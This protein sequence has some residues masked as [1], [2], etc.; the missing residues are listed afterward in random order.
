MNLAK[1]ITEDLVFDKP[2]T[3]TVY[4]KADAPEAK[5]WLG[6]PKNIFLTYAKENP[7][8]ER[9]KKLLAEDRWGT[10]VFYKEDLSLKRWIL[11]KRMFHLYN[12]RFKTYFHTKE[13]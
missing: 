10:T 11:L 4:V 2:Y 12:K 7:A 13:G 5:L 3:E 1:F 9:A 6:V 8:K